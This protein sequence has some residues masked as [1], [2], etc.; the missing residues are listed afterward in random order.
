[1]LNSVILTFA[2]TLCSEG[3]MLITATVK[4]EVK[5]ASYD[6]FNSF[7]KCALWQD[8][9]YQY[10]MFNL[11]NLFSKPFLLSIYYLKDKIDYN[12]SN[13]ML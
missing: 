8:P 7:L 2:L 5:M 6:E 1:M 13:I 3:K 11:N 4:D 12:Y 10:L 9:Y